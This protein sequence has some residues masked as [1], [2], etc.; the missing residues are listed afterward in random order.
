MSDKDKIAM[1][2]GIVMGLSNALH[3]RSKDYEGIARAKR[4]RRIVKSLGISHEE[5]AAANRLGNRRY[6]V[7]TINGMVYI[8]RLADGASVLLQG[9]DARTFESQIETP[10]LSIEEQDRICE[11]YDAVMRV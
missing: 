11:N 8:I 6:K 10:L 4:A 2:A 3:S 7:E 9:D 1:L 5:M